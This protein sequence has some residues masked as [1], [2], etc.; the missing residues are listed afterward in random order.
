MKAAI[1]ILAILYVWGCATQDNP[2][3]EIV[4]NG[5][6]RQYRMYVSDSTNRHDD[7]KWYFYANVLP[8]DSLSVI[9]HEEYYESENKANKHEA[10][11]FIV[12][13]KNSESHRT[14]SEPYVREWR[15]DRMRDVYFRN[16]VDVADR[17]MDEK[18]LEKFGGFWVF[19]RKYQG[20]FYLHQDW[21]CLMARELTDSTWV[22]IDMEVFPR[23]CTALYGDHNAFTLV[24]D[25]DPILFELVDPERE[26]YRVGKTRYMIPNR[27][28]H[29][30]PIIEYIGTTGDLISLS[31]PFD[32]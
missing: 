24:V 16:M 7:Q 14:F 2:V 11:A 28:R 17:N 26:I 20:E 30:F 29:E 19:V 18:L 22:Q 10:Y 12:H 13:N 27:R 5:L 21:T 25:G 6:H 23:P 1:I 4:G 31:I 8:T 3:K 15:D 32:E 9:G